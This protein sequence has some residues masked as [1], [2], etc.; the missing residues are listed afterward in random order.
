MCGDLGTKLVF[1]NEFKKLLLKAKIE[2]K[3]HYLLI[4]FLTVLIY[5]FSGKMRDFYAFGNQLE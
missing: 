2:E 3:N 5:I 4:M 1:I